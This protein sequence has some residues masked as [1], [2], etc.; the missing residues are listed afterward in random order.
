MDNNNGQEILTIKYPELVCVKFS[1]E[2]GKVVD[3]QKNINFDSLFNKITSSKEINTL[4]GDEADGC[5]N[6]SDIF[7][8]IYQMFS[9]DEADILPCLALFCEENNCLNNLRLFKGEPSHEQ[10]QM[11]QDETKNNNSYVV[12]PIGVE[13]DNYRG[14]HYVTGMCIKG[15][16][17][18]FD[19][20]RQLKA[21]K[22]SDEQKVV[23][24]NGQDFQLLNP[25]KKYQSELTGNCG[26]WTMLMCAKLANSHGDISN[27]I[28]SCKDEY[29]I[30]PQIL[31]EISEEIYKLSKDIFNKNRGNISKLALETAG[32][33]IDTDK[34]LQNVQKSA[35]NGDAINSDAFTHLGTFVKEIKKD[36][37]DTFKKALIPGISDLINKL[38]KEISHDT[39]RQ[40]KKLMKEHNE[41]RVKSGKHH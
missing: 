35:E 21:Q 19:S 27:V 16:F 32:I 37:I 36:K 38:P 11:I 39:E 41:H 14:G 40:I 15:D 23:S 1:A 31:Q 10:L 26:F 29:H 33:V 7:G 8:R 2:T 6:I 4:T 18:I 34:I 20:T 3:I 12:F 30:K 22:L 25:D 9:T 17:Y 24:I 5:N 28:E 13:G